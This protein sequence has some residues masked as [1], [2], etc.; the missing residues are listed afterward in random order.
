MSLLLVAC[1]FTTGR[2]LPIN[3][4]IAAGPSLEMFGLTIRHPVLGALIDRL[5]QPYVLGVFGLTIAAIAI[6]LVLGSEFTSTFYRAMTL[7]VAASSCAVISSTPA[8]VLS[9]I[10][11]GGRQSAMFKRGEHV[12]TAE[13][14]DAVAFDKTVTL[15]RG[16][17]QLTDVFVREGTVDVTLTEDGLL[18]IVAAVQDRSEHHLARATVRAAEARSLEVPDAERF[19]S[20]AGKGVNADVEGSTTHIGNRSC[21]ET[22]LG[23]VA[24]DGLEPGLD[25]LRT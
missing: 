23:D 17:T 6:P 9:A 8:A 13:R 11:S 3:G 25:R 7:M 12:E 1:A 19:Q 16:D 5:Q 24:I 18:S 20:V 14:I 2:I 21:F 15:T 22:V 10:A 4:R